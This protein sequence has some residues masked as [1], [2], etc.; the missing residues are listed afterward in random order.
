M[1][2]AAV[3]TN[4]LRPFRPQASRASASSLRRLSLSSPCASAAREARSK[5]SRAFAGRRF[6]RQ[7]SPRLKSILATAALLAS[8]CGFEAAASMSA[9]ARRAPRTRA[10]MR[11][12]R[13]FRTT[14][15]G[16]R[17]PP[18]STRI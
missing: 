5:H 9:L 3:R 18:F 8:H 10:A 13:L 1:G 6:S 7:S 12:G 4:F 11:V 14:L 2:F 17:W 15:S 16:G